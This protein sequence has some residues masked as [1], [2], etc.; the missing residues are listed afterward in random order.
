MS[1]SS[2]CSDHGILV[3]EGKKIDFLG[4][5]QLACLWFEVYSVRIW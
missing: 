2:F 5:S 1:I 3:Q 4:V